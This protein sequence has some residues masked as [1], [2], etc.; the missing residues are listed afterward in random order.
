MVHWT[1]NTK[2]KFK[3]TVQAPAEEDE[4]PPPTAGSQRGGSRPTSQGGHKAEGEEA[5]QEDPAIQD[6]AGTEREGEGTARG[7]GDE[8]G[9]EEKSLTEGEKRTGRLMG[10]KTLL[11]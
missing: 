7:D 5:M 9:D 10:E 1:L 3:I 11:S 8:K 6:G 4:E 2:F